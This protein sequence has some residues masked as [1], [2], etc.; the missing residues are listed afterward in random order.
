MYLQ[1]APE[2]SMTSLS[3]STRFASASRHLP[4]TPCVAV[5]QLAMSVSARAVRPVLTARRLHGGPPGHRGRC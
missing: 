3:A 4:S 5:R 1:G 2:R